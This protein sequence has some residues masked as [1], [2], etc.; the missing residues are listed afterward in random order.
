MVN[1][2]FP[3]ISYRVSQF[4]A[5]LRTTPLETSDLE[6]A[7]ALLSNQELVLF[8]R[9]QPSEQAHALHTLQTLKD[10]GEIHPDLLTA[11]LLHDV[12]KV[13]HPLHLW[14]RV[15][16]VLVKQFAPG[17]V[18]T[19]GRGS[20]RGWRRPFVIARKHPQWGAEL[21]GEAD[22]SPLTIHLIREHQTKIFPEIPDDLTNHLLRILQA[23]DNQN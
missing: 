1:H 21:A 13:R 6:P 15:I 9:M 2:W 19:W 12:G 22:S 11:A 4:W 23:A 7:K 3:R 16:I 5:A 8:K 17:R 14:E 18:N 10:Q 20:A